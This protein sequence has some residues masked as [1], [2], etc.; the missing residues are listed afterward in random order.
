MTSH[1]AWCLKNNNIYF[2]LNKQKILVGSDFN[3]DIILKEAELLEPFHAILEPKSFSVKI[4][5]FSSTNSLY[6][7]DLLVQNIDHA[8]ESDRITICR[9]TFILERKVLEY[10]LVDL[11]EEEDNTPLSEFQI[12]PEKKDKKK[13]NKKRNLH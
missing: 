13:R 5:N 12:K 7:N 2:K 3:C 10:I 1:H 6:I 11:S 4:T 9:Q 8:F